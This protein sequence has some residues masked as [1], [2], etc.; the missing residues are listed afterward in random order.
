VITVT[1]VALRS[2]FCTVGIAERFVARS[3]PRSRALANVS[4]LRLSWLIHSSA[5]SAVSR[6]AIRSMDATLCSL[7]KFRAGTRRLIQLSSKCTMSP[8]STTT[9][10][11]W[12]PHLQGLMAGRVPWRR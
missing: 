12:Q 3:I 2:A 1:G 5:C 11:F 4:A 9:P 7:L 8:E 10:R 6:V